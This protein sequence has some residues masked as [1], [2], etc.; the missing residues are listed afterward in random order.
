MARDRLRSA[1][2]SLTK[3][4]PRVLLIRPPAVVVETKADVIEC[5]IGP[6]DQVREHEDDARDDQ[7]DQDLDGDGQ[8]GSPDSLTNVAI[9]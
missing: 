8:G 9:G 5:L 4:A 6:E 1:L 7:G 2:A 3:L